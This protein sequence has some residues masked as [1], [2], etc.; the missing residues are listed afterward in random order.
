MKSLPARPRRFYFYSA[1]LRA[2]RRGPYEAREMRANA[3]IDMRDAQDC[4]V[5]D[6][7]VRR[8]APIRGGVA[9]QCAGGS[10]SDGNRT[11][12]S[13]G[14]N[15]NVVLRARDAQKLAQAKRAVEEMLERVRRA[16]SN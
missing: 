11:Y 9:L 13:H 15:T 8:D 2:R 3:L 12:R 4:A 7:L 5:L 10:A 1:P 14:P 6:L 16:Q